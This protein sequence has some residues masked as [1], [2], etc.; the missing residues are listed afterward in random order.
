MHR[1]SGGTGDRLARRC[2]H[3]ARQ[4]WLKIDSRGLTITR[5]TGLGQSRPPEAGC[6][7]CSLNSTHGKTTG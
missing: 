1:A 2:Q 3:V 7:T 5:D 4:G 6:V